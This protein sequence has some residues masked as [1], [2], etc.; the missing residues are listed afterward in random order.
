M[1]VIEQLLVG[2]QSDETC[3]DGIVVTDNHIAVIDGSTSKTS[4][5]VC[6]FMANGRFAM[7]LVSDVLASLPAQTTLSQFCRIVTEAVADA[8]DYYNQPQSEIEKHPEKRL[9]CSAAIYNKWHREVWLVGDCQCIVGG[10]L[11]ENGKP[12]EALYAEKRSRYIKDHHL[13]VDDVR[14]HDFGRDQIIPELIA[15]MMHQ[16]KTYAVIDGTPIYIN[17][18]KTVHVPSNSDVV[19][20]TDGYP[21][22]CETLAESESKLQQL[23]LDDPLLISRFKA[24]KAYMLGNRSFDDRAYIRFKV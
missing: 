5:R 9:T 24:T 11:Y 10:R 6:R 16:N 19:L 14:Q 17:G 1:E 2:K 12:E 22:L 18:I 3:E 7:Q 15:S 8:Y 20:A 4:S 23:L 21:F 13:S